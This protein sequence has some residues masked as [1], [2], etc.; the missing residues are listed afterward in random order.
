M[1]D[2][3]DRLVEGYRQASASTWWDRD[4]ATVRSELERLR[5]RIYVLENMRSENY[6][7]ALDNAEAEVRQLRALI[8]GCGDVMEQVGKWLQSPEIPTDE[9]LASIDR[10]GE[11]TLALLSASPSDGGGA[12]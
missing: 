3:L 12:K 2:A 11:R 10:L 6:I 9:V 4:L 7:E 5:S 1:D 8:L